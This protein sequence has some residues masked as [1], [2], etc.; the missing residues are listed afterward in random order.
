MVV[1]GGGE[2]LLMSEVPLFT[3]KLRLLDRSAGGGSR[4]GDTSLIIKLLSVVL[5]SVVLRTGLGGGGGGEGPRFCSK[6]FLGA[7][8][9][10]P[11]SR[12][13]EWH[14]L[15]LI[16][17]GLP[18]RLSHTIFKKRR[19]SK[20]NSHIKPSTYSFNCNRKGHIDGWKGTG[21][22]REHG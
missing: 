9:S 15:T 3:T 8:G 5:L 11:L 12:R 16:V 20:A 7:Q 6:L 4:A 13:G 22:S 17:R 18:P 19:C 10:P 2:L 1:L 21:I 14:L